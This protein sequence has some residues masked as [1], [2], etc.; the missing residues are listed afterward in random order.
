VLDK[1][2]VDFKD[3]LMSDTGKMHAPGDAAIHCSRVR[4]VLKNLTHTVFSITQLNKVVRIGEPQNVLHRFRVDK[5]YAF[6][7]IV[8]FLSSLIKFM[9]WFTSLHGSSW[10]NK[11]GTLY[12][13]NICITELKGLQAT[14]IKKRNAESTQKRIFERYDL[15]P[16][17]M[18]QYVNWKERK[19][20]LSQLLAFTPPA[21][22]DLTEDFKA[23]LY[24]QI[25]VWKSHLMLTMF[26]TNAKR[27]GDVCNLTV[28]EFL[29]TV[30][31]HGEDHFVFVMRHKMDK[32]ELCKINIH[33]IM[34]QCMQNYLT[35]VR[36][37]EN[38]V[39]EHF[40]LSTVGTKLESS[41]VNWII[42]NLWAHFCEEEKVD[43]APRIGTRIIRKIMTTSVRSTGAPRQIQEG[44]A[45]HMAHRVAH[46]TQSSNS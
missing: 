39:S 26:I 12:D 31:H 10:L 35:N 44:L 13:A 14:Y 38:S 33:G 25:L 42:K 2:L 27:C 17:H 46:G 8:N 15:E 6:G 7:S 40:F 5:H 22:D 23:E 20:V 24:R 19:E 11:W 1:L 16:R 9:T 45:V 41:Q 4:N 32:V 21:T 43:P 37:L 3:Y 36:P 28:T 30:R 34:Y 18:A 29:K